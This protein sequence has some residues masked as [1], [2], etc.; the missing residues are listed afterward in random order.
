MC[1]RLVID[2]SQISLAE[3]IEVELD[4]LMGVGGA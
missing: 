1:R 4:T 2:F 3:S